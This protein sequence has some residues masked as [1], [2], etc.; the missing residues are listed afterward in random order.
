MKFVLCKYFSID[1]KQGKCNQDLNYFS[2]TILLFYIEDKKRYKELKK[3]LKK[4]ILSKF[5]NPNKLKMAEMTFL[6][7]DLLSCPWLDEPF[8]KDLLIHYDIKNTSE[9]EAILELNKKQWWFTKWT[10]FD[11][12]KALES[13][14]S[15]EVY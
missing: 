3:V 7:F 1:I 8:K 13:K 4:H 5:K 2:I 11:F 9:Q 10:D 14:K 12:C 6:L 15:L